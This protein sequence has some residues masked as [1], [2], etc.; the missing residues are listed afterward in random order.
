MPT[1]DVRNVQC[2]IWSVILL[3]QRLLRL[4]NAMAQC[5]VSMPP[6]RGCLQTS[7]ILEVGALWGITCLC[8]GHAT[9][10]DG[11]T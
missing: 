8:W 4:E 6:M 1:C 9:N 11:R 5:Q 7:M 3:M 10:M 2:P